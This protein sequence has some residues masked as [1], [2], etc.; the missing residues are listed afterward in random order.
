MCETKTT[1][2][3]KGKAASKVLATFDKPRNAVLVKDVRSEYPFVP[4][5]SPV[6]VVVPRNLVM[7][8]TV[9]SSSSDPRVRFDAI[10]FEDYLIAQRK[11]RQ[12]FI[13]AVDAFFNAHL[14]NDK[15]SHDQAGVRGISNFFRFVCSTVTDADASRQA[16]V[17]EAV[18]RMTKALKLPFEVTSDTALTP[19]GRMLRENN[20]YAP[21][22]GNLGQARKGNEQ[23]VSE[24]TAAVNQAQAKMTKVVDRITELMEEIE[25]A[26]L[27]IRKEIAEVSHGQV[28]AARMQDWDI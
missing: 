20:G 11:N 10:P 1:P 12:A 2:G 17:R 15:F 5:R 14:M 3:P 19:L 9:T 21:A 8:T 23:N 22:A 7:A 25:A 4:L 28:L 18:L 27:Q 13:T 26:R 24:L 16:T 6:S